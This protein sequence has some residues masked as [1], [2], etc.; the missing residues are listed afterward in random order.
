M[1]NKNIY[2]AL[3]PRPLDASSS[4]IENMVLRLDIEKNAVWMQDNS[5]SFDHVF[6][7]L[8]SN[9]LVYNVLVPESLKVLLEGFNFTILAYGQTGSGKSYTMG[10]HY[11]QSK[12]INT[13]NAGIIPRILQDLFDAIKKKE[14]EVETAIK[15]SFMEVMIY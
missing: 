5:Y 3:R 1:A 15:V 6:D 14:E 10:T 7:S 4:C 9:A 12:E 13:N 11:D 2:V 8:D